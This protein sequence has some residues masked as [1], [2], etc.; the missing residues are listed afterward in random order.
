MT[1]KEKAEYILK[2]GGGWAMKRD[3]DEVCT[4]VLA[5]CSLL[6]TRDLLLN[7]RLTLATAS[8]DIGEI[9]NLVHDLGSGFQP[10]LKDPDATIQLAPRS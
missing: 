8:S 2:H 1:I 10:E 4:W 7:L 3:I 6:E 5:A 9:A